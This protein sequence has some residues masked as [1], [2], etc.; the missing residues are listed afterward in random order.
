MTKIINSM[1]TP[2]LSYTYPGKLNTELIQKPKIQTPALSE[3]FR[4]MQGIRCG[5]YINLVQPLTSVL[6]K[7]TADCAPTYTQSGS[8]TDRKIETGL[9]EINL[10]WCK[11]EFAAVCSN[12]SDSDLIGDGLDGY[13]LGNRLR[14]LIFDEVLEAARLDLFKIIF[15]SNNSLGTGSTN[16]YSAID[17]VFTKF[18]DGAGS[19]CVEPVDNTLPNQHDSVLASNQARNTFRLLWGNSSNLLKQLPSSQKQMWVSGS[20]WE[21]YYDSIINDCCTE[22]SWKAG[23]DGLGDRLFYRGIEVFPLW[24][25]DE[26][27]Q[28]ETDNPYY[29][30][31]R[32]F[33]VYTAKNN[34]LVGVERASD[35]NNLELCYDC[36]TKTTLIQGEMRVGYNYA[37]CDLISWAK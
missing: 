5:E 22:G 21:N 8:I 2:N 32:H 12:L 18:F 11:K 16:K 6:S 26:A 1:Y 9:F 35:L 27:L 7:G 29:D 15:L 3:L 30:I 28:N 10:E 31:I 37:Q 23:Q 25:I 4:I 33:A 19:Y 24:A 34:H 14:T 20:M 17:G 13:E 36:R